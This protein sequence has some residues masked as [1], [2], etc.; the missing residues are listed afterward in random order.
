MSDKR[1]YVYD[2]GVARPVLQWAL[3]AGF[4]LAAAQVA[5]SAFSAAKAGVRER[6]WCEGWEQHL[7]YVAWLT[8]RFCAIP[9]L[10]AAGLWPAEWCEEAPV[11]D[12]RYHVY[13]NGVARPVLRWALDA[14]FD[15]AAAQVAASAFSAARAG[16]REEEWRRGWEQHLTYVA[17]L[18]ERFCAIPDLKAAGLWPPEWCEEAPVQEP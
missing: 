17:W 3:G 12:K 15:L 7:T 11:I 16:V 9:D 5:A 6:E 1:Y 4:D 13:D 14:G 10:K 8:E 18:T 2:N